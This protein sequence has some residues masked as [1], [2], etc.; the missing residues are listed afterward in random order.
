M[1]N[2]KRGLI[3][4]ARALKINIKEL[5][6]IS[7][8]KRTLKGRHTHFKGYKIALKAFGGNSKEIV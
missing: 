5:R 2:F 6:S 1:G 7:I 8:Y 4:F 3:L